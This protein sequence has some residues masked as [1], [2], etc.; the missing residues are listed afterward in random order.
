MMQNSLHTGGVTGSI[1]VAPTIKCQ[2]N[3]YLG[4]GP[5]PFSP[6]LGVNGLRNSPKN[7]GK[8]GGKVFMR[9]SRVRRSVSI[10]R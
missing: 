10:G 5:L 1:P 4:D 6:A 7:W 9:C 3:Q 8:I 2:E